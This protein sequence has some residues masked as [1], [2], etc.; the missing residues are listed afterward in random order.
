MRHM[1]DP[2]P[3]TKPFLAYTKKYGWVVV[4]AVEPGWGDGFSTIPG[5]YGVA[6]NAILY[7]ADL[8]RINS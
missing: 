7:R 2:T 8:P 6:P 4:E 5:K 1:I 3:T